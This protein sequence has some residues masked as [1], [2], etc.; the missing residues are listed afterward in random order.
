MSNKSCRHLGHTRGWKNPF[1]FSPAS[2]LLLSGLLAATVALQTPLAGAD[3]GPLPPGWAGADVGVGTTPVGDSSLVGT[4]GT[5]IWTV[6]GGGGDIWYHSDEF[7]YV[8][9]PLTGD[10]TITAR[11]TSMDGGEW[12]KGGLMIRQSLDP[13]SPYAFACNGIDHGPDFQWRNTQ[14]YWAGNDA[15][16]TATIPYYLRLQ[17]T[18]SIFK[19]Y[20]STDGTTWTQLADGNGL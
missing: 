15:A 16:G 6:K 7:H 18:G 20:Y 13:G 12:A 3:T 8:Y 1:F 11:I 19:A 17:R 9:L 2:W 5:A 4:G 10:A 14:A